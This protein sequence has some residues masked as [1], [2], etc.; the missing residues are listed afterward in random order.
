MQ[1]LISE[2]AHTIKT[3]YEQLVQI[4]E[5]ESAQFP[6]P[7]KWSK[8]QIIGHL[9]DS[10]SN[11]HQRFVRVQHTDGLQMPRYEQEQWV[12][13]QNY[14]G[15]PWPELLAFWK[16]YNQH[17]L[18]VI[19]HIPAEKLEHTVCIGEGEPVTLGFLV[20]DYVQHLQQHLRQ[21]LG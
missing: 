16:G 13:A 12:T 2:F 1:Q 6:A 17:L 8:K 14:Q 10:A 18:H 15:E 11:N 9:L 4:T 21:I 7:G 5:E 20:E 19:A 3:A